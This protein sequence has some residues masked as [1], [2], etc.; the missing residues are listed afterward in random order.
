[1]KNIQELRNELLHAFD[2]VKSGDLKTPIAK[3][4]TNAAGKVI[5]TIKM[6]LEYAALRKET[7]DIDFLNVKS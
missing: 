3:E 6:Q 4:M 2:G 7:P 5:G 1:M